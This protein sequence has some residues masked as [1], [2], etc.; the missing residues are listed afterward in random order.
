MALEGKATFTNQD[1]TNW[2]K[3]VENPGSARD[4]RQVNN[5]LT[6]FSRPDVGLL[7]RSELNNDTMSKVT[8]TDM[9]QVFVQDIL[10]PLEAWAH[11]PNAVLAINEI[12][13]NIKRN[14]DGYQDIYRQIATIYREKSPYINRDIEAKRDM[15][16]GDISQNPGQTAADI[17]RELGITSYEGVRLV[18]KQL[19]ASGQVRVEVGK[20]GRKH[21]S[22]ANMES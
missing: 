11:D 17:A 3:N 6:F 7:S 18:L 19:T 22:I 12:R 4:R 15:V 2:I 16:Y 13:Q 20:M 8:L 21:Y 10:K 5:V 1:V 9:G 14:P